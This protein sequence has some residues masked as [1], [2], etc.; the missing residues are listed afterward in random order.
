MRAYGD[1]VKQAANILGM[2]PETFRRV[3]EL[4]GLATLSAYPAYHLYK[5]VRDDEPYG[6]HVA[7]LAGLGLLAAP[8][9][10]RKH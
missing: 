5:A 9:F 3:A 4:G 8:E 2:A 10:L 6:Q 1:G 7:E